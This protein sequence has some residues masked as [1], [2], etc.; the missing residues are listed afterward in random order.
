M[1]GRRDYRNRSARIPHNA[2]KHVRLILPADLLMTADGGSLAR[3]SRAGVLTAVE[4]QKIISLLPD[5]L[6]SPENHWVAVTQRARVIVHSADRV[7]PEELSTYEALAD[8]QWKGRIVIRSSS[9]SYNQ[10]LMATIIEANGEE[11]AL[12]WAE[13]IVANMA[14]SPQGNDRDQVRAVAAGLADIAVVNTYYIGLLA[15]SEDEADREVAEAVKIFFPNQEGRG[16]H[17]NIS[18]IGVTKASKKQELA[19]QFIAFLLSDEVQSIYNTSTHEYAVSKTVEPSELQKE[20]GEFKADEVPL[21]TLAD[22]NADAVRLFD[23]A[24]WE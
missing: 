7:K 9:N 24:G 15:K 23:E 18:G 1:V 20:W 22:H 17:F 19:E 11:K 21:S 10:S 12:A 8:E 3:A 2:R 5:R 4:D 14:R 13:A 6:R 16:A